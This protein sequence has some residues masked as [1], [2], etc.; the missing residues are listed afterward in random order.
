MAGIHD[1]ENG[2]PPIDTIIREISAD[3]YEASRSFWN[4]KNPYTPE[5]VV[6]VQ[7]LAFGCAGEAA[8]RLSLWFDLCGLTHLSAQEIK[9]FK[10]S[11]QRS[12]AS[13]SNQLRKVTPYPG[14]NGMISNLR[15]SS[16]SSNGRTKIPSSFDTHP[17][18]PFFQMQ[19]ASNDPSSFSLIHQMLRHRIS[20][21]IQR[22]FR[23]FRGTESEVRCFIT[24][25]DSKLRETFERLSVVSK[26]W[27]WPVTMG[28]EQVTAET[29]VP[30]C[31]SKYT[32]TSTATVSNIWDGFISAGIY[33]T[34]G[35][36][37]RPS[38]PRLGVLH[39]LSETRSIGK[40]KGVIPHIESQT[41]RNGNDAWKS[42]ILD[43]NEHKDWK[44]I[45]DH[46]LE[47]NGKSRDKCM[48]LSSA[49][50]ERN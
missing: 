34:G 50:G 39:T 37:E 1:I 10:R 2:S 38:R 19:P 7:E 4:K 27:K 16:S 22:E 31:G 36:N 29:P 18:K 42:I 5:E 24:S 46:Y 44:V 28:R 8:S 49:N 9:R 13:T 20:V 25:Q 43:S 45:K 17:H 26:T 14:S 3:E 35:S 12:K 21:L 41:N 15:E 33:E 47:A 11:K 32:P 23:A 6:V 48:P 40:E 30:K